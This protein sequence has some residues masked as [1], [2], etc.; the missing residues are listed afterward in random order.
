MKHKVLYILLFA[1]NLN[2]TQAQ[3]IEYDS[4]SVQVSEINIANGMDVFKDHFAM[5]T[6]GLISG[7]N[8]EV[9]DIIHYENR[10]RFED[11]SYN[12]YWTLSKGLY[13]YIED[14]EFLD[15]VSFRRIEH[16]YF[17]GRV[18]YHITKDNEIKVVS[19]QWNTYDGLDWTIRQF[20]RKN[21]RK[22][23]ILKYDLLVEIITELLGEPSNIEDKHT[24]RDDTSWTTESGLN[25]YLYRFTNYSE[26]DLYIY[27]D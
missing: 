2:L 9:L 24:W 10:N 16:P 25:I 7:Q 26:I 27:K 22:V 20:L 11:A 14:H 18:N 8:F 13:P 23:F 17:E 1:I 19:Y 5:I 3:V 12:H 15:P 6:S 21:A 4:L